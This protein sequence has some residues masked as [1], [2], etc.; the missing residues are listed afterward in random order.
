MVNPMR[1]LFFVLAMFLG[2]PCISAIGN[3]FTIP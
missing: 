3:P 2:L 1:F